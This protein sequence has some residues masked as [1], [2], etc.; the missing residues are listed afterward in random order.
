MT[1]EE[2]EENAPTTSTCVNLWFDDGNVVLQAGESDSRFKVY[3]GILSRESSVFKDMFSLPQPP[4]S[5]AESFDGFPLV[6]L[7][8]A[9]DSLKLLLS[10]MFDPK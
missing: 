1:I 9:G 10:V 3:R 7:H 5:I 2:A 4:S 6:R 8:D